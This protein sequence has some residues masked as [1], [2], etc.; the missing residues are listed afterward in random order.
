VGQE[1][2]LIK[3]GCETLFDDYPEVPPQVRERMAE[4]S[5]TVHGTISAVRGLA[6]DLRPPG[7]DQL[8]LAQSVFQLCQEFSATTGLRVDFQAAGMDD[9]PIDPEI[10]I[11]LYRLFQEALNNIQKHAEAQRVVIRLVASYPNVILRIEDDGRGFDV[12]GR[13]LQASSEKRMGLSSMEERVNLLNG[14]LKIQSRLMVGTNIRIEIPLK[15][16]AAV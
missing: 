6:Y 10:E 15:E 8:G 7:L 4:L 5:H 12:E 13:L 9:L 11:N 1:L 16:K 2:S 3:I 14:T